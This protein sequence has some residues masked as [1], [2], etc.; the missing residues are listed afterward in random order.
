MPKYNPRPRGRNRVNRA[1]KRGLPPGVPVYTGDQP[2]TPI[3]VRVM[4]YDAD[5]V[6]ER[7]SC[8]PT[9]LIGLMSTPGVTWV[10]VDGVHNVEVVEEVCRTVQV[11]PLW[12]ED[13]VNV[14]SRSKGEWLDGQLLLIL[15]S[16]SLV[17]LDGVRSVRSEQI[18]LVSGHGWV[19]SFQEHPGD[20]WDP[21]RARLR[22][23][24]GRL[25]RQRSEHLIHALMDAVIDGYFTVLEHLELAVEDLED[26]ALDP[27]A[28]D[29]PA[30]YA[31]FKAE[32][33]IVRAAVN[34]LR[35]AVITTL[36]GG[37]ST[38]PKDL[39]PFFQDLL[40]HATLARENAEALRERAVAAL[41][42]QLAVA[43]QSM[44]EVIRVLTVVSTIFMPLTF[45]V[46][47]YGMNFDVMPELRQPLGYPVT[48]GVM[49]ALTL[50]MLAFFRRRGWL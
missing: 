38:P 26:R 28:S 36:R 40:D 22:A 3:S 9:E 32:L 4:D 7:T 49:G 44:N 47:V 14:G 45:I 29:L 25:R 39:L 18:G 21:L 16:L 48:L 46:G 50:G 15:R 41:E 1:A 5:R 10:N 43:N 31:S 37:D 27:R 13:I 6:D 8:T 34:P 35:E 30:R 24:H 11:H 12:T 17:D 33:N 2:D 23:G 20:E 42:V 19:I